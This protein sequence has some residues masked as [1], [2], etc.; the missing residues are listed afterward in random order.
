MRKAAAQALRARVKS[1]PRSPDE[2]FEVVARYE[3]GRRRGLRDAAS[4]A[5]GVAGERESGR[6]EAVAATEA[7]DD[8]VQPGALPRRTPRQTAVPGRAEPEARPDPRAPEEA[9][10][11]VA[12]Y[13][14]GRRRARLA[15]PARDDDANGPARVEDD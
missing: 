11:L 6:D 15:D 3:S 13:E 4:G 5:A 12:R 14:W 1:A 8:R 9:F 7:V 2:V 10:E